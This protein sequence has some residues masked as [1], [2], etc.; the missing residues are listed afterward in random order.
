MKKYT[1]FLSLCVLA[2]TLLVASGCAHHQSDRYGR[3][4]VPNGPEIGS[5]DWINWVDQRVDTRYA[6][7]V[8]P[9][10]GSQEWYAIVDHV[11][12]GDYSRDYYRSYELDQYSYPDRNYYPGYNYGDS[13]RRYSSGRRYSSNRSF[14]DDRPAAKDYRPLGVYHE[15]NRGP[16]CKPDRR[17]SERCGPPEDRRRRCIGNMEWKRAVDARLRS[18]RIPPPP[19]R[20]DP[21]DAPLAPT[22]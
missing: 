11:V 10:P 1:K 9:D 19:A 20:S 22:H 14:D 16:W 2:V 8:R 17:F 3:R 4:Y 18:G 5:P 13:D 15:P 21:W 12:F 7:G 6:N